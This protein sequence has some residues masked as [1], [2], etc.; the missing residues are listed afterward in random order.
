MDLIKTLG[1]FIF[2]ALI[3]AVLASVGYFIIPTFIQISRSIGGL[4]GA[5]IGL[6]ISIILWF[7][8]G[9]KFVSKAGSIML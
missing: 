7:I 2:Y 4:I 5:I 6:F 8:V 9:E 3:I 1:I